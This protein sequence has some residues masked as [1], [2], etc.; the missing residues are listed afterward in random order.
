M[1]VTFE[2]TGVRNGLGKVRGLAFGKD[3]GGFPDE[4][5]KASAK[6]EVDAEK[7]SVKLTFY[8]LKIKEA[9]FSI[10]HD[11]KELGRIEK[12]FLGVPKQGIAVSNWKG[13]G[14]PTYKKS[15]VKLKPQMRVS[16]KYF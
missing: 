8:K 15:I 7:G 11:E 3:N 13:L 9:A 4:I 16:L 12:T 6:A 2:I 10:F 5:S 14:K 1:N